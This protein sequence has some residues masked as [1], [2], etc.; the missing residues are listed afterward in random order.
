MI[1]K[2][3]KINKTIVDK[4]I[5]IYL[6][7][8]KFQAINKKISSIAKEIDVSPSTITK[9]LKKSGYNGWKE[10][11]SYLFLNYYQNIKISKSLING[12]N[13]IKNQKLK[14]IEYIDSILFQ[15]LKK[16]AK[17]INKSK[18]N[19]IDRSWRYKKLNK[20]VQ[21]KFRYFGF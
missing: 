3:F 6:N 8:L 12:N 15:D 20:N 1:F 11:T 13:E 2:P 21:E 18:K 14:N 4:K 9:F 10:Y 19:Y 5:S 7:N 16:L 17:T